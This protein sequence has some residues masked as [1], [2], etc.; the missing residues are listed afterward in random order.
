MP[1]I[2][3][4]TS[5]PS[6][7]ISSSVHARRNGI[8]WLG[9]M[10]TR[11]DDSRL[12]QA[13]SIFQPFAVVLRFRILAF[14]TE[15]LRG[16]DGQ[17]IREEQLPDDALRLIEERIDQRAVSLYQDTPFEYRSGAWIEV[18]EPRWWISTIPRQTS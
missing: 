3:Q 7:G 16:R 5:S 10:P 1:Y 14:A 8:G 13:F 12:I 18:G 2:A 15:A 6:R 11:T 17:D 4:A 9:V